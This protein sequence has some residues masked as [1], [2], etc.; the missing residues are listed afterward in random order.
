MSELTETILQHNEQGF[1]VCVGEYEA[2]MSGHSDTEK[3]QVVYDLLGIINKAQRELKSLILTKNKYDELCEKLAWMHADN[4]Q[5]SQTS[6][7]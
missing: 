4:Q 3:A 2:L 6:K 7:K 5:D 1:L